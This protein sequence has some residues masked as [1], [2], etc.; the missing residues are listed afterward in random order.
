M[1]LKLRQDIEKRLATQVVEDAI[2]EGYTVSLD[3]G[4][5]GYEIEDSTDKDAILKEMFATDDEVLCLKKDGKTRFVSLIYGNDGYD[6][7][8]DYTARLDEDVMKETNRLA[9]LFMEGDY[10]ELYK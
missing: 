7:V 2:K 5:L 10:K 8:S 9:D 4:G 3:N 1:Q 6:V